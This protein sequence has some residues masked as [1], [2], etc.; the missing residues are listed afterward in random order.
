MFDSHTHVDTIRCEGIEKM[1]LG[2]VKRLLLALGPNGSTVHTTLL[3]QSQ[4]FLTTHSTRIKS[5]GIEPFVAPGVHP[6]SIPRDY[7]EALRKL[8]VMLHQ[9]GVVEIGEIG[10]HTNDSTEEIV[11]EGQSR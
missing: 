11:F 7:D 1:A 5:R 10:I 9:D 4:Q 3:H 8:P 2:A 6:I